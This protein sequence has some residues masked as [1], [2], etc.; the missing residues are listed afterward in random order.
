MRGKGA[1]IRV[2]GVPVGITPA[3]A[4]KS[5]PLLILVNSGA[6]HPRVCGEKASRPQQAWD[7][8]GSPPRMRG[9][10]PAQQLI[11]AVRGITPAYA[12]TSL[13]AICVAGTR[14]DHPRVCGESCKIVHNKTPFRDHPRVCGEKQPLKTPV[15][16]S[17]GSPPRMRGQDAGR[18]CCVGNGGITPAYAGRSDTL[19]PE[20]HYGQ[21]VVRGLCR[22]FKR[23]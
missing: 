15:S 11:P 23:A 6:D 13:G 12:G 20:A 7:S 5:P 22:H 21:Q 3:Y 14:R 1:A 18:K 19:H 8:L 2:D 9:K 10:E 4:G 16:A 17:L